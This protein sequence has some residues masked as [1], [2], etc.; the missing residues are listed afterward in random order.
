MKMVEV[1]GSFDLSRCL[2][3]RRE[4]RAQS[5]LWHGLT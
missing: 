3:E 2:Q 1:D 5:L 4:A